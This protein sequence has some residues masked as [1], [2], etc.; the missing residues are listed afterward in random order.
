MLYSKEDEI[1][2]RRKELS[3]L[4]GQAGIMIKQLAEAME[5]LREGYAGNP[6]HVIEM[7]S[8]EEV[9]DMAKRI[10]RSKVRISELEGDRSSTRTGSD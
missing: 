5:H 9:T 3:R 7:P 10:H 6:F 1:S 4:Q 2:N 8:R